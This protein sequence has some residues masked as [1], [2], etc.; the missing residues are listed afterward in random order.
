MA[1]VR[2]RAFRGPLTRPPRRGPRR[3]S[4]A[5]DLVAG[6]LRPR[7]RARRPRGAPRPRGRE[8]ERTRPRSR[9]WQSRA[10]P[11]DA[12]RGR[13][14]GPRDRRDHDDHSL[15][16][17]KHELPRRAARRGAGARVA[18]RA[19]RAARCARRGRTL[20]V[21]R[22][23]RAA[24]VARRRSRS[25]RRRRGLLRGLPP[26]RAR[27]AGGSSG[28]P[29]PRACSGPAVRGLRSADRVPRPR[30]APPRAF[31]RARAAARRGARCGP[32]QPPPRSSP[33]P[34]PTVVQNFRRIGASEH[35]VLLRSS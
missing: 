11:P 33:G 10:H 8:R 28:G 5:H 25:P 17:A 9:R 3:P 31:R 24:R 19:G 14:G 29:A 16:R 34:P 7:G 30:S 2:S 27:P 4:G 20:T 12:P 18:A 21:P 15:E 26:L 13:R 6:R 35:R 1:R 23:V 22:S 32:G